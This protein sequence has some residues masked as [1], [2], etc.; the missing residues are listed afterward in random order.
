MLI[1]GPRLRSCPSIDDIDVA[2]TSVRR[3]SHIRLTHAQG[4]EAEWL[5]SNY[6]ERTGKL[7]GCYRTSSFPTM[8]SSSWSATVQ[9]KL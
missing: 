5:I 6:A 7:G 4:R 8:P 3:Q 9:T 2:L 1:P